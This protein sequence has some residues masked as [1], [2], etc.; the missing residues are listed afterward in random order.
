MLP[1]TFKAIEAETLNGAYSNAFTPNI[2]ASPR[3]PLKS[4]LRIIII[5]FLKALSPLFYQLKYHTNPFCF[6]LNIKVQYEF[7]EGK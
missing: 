6:L 7:Y 5:Q 4:F 2:P 3:I 1:G